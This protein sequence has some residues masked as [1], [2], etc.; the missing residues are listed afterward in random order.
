MPIAEVCEKGFS[1]GTAKNYQ[2]SSTYPATECSRSALH[3]QPRC[4]AWCHQRAEGT[5]AILENR[6]STEDGKETVLPAFVFLGT[7]R[8]KTCRQNPACPTASLGANTQLRSSLGHAGDKAEQPSEAQRLA[9]LLRLSQEGNCCGCKDKLPL[10][11]RTR[12]W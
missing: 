6:I 10:P 11:G 1:L 2:S 3:C 5:R 8:K 4:A 7:L 12:H 9:V